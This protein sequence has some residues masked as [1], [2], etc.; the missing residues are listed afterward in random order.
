MAGRTVTSL[1]PAVLAQ[2]ERQASQILARDEK[3]RA[4]VGSR[5]YSIP[6][7]QMNEISVTALQAA[8]SKIEDLKLP[9]FAL[10]A[11]WRDFC[12]DDG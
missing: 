1:S 10:Q 8:Q 6:R 9:P 3:D 7:D 4:R 5:R 12:E 2:L 11:W